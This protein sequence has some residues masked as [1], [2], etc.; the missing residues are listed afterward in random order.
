MGLRLAK[1]PAV[2]PLVVCDSQNR[3]QL[4]GT[5]TDL[6]ADNPSIPMFD[7]MTNTCDKKRWL[8]LSLGS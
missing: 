4:T 1:V 5:L 2:V 3:R 7:S 6:V 8:R